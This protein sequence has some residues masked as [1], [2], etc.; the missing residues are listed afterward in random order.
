[1]KKDLLLIE[2]LIFDKDLWSLCI[3]IEYSG[4][5]SKRTKLEKQIEK[6]LQAG[7]KYEINGIEIKSLLD[8][9]KAT[10]H[11]RLVNKGISF[12]KIFCL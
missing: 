3:G 2:N 11:M 12:D 9:R 10:E 6:L 4:M 7:E 8:F 5:E 1:M